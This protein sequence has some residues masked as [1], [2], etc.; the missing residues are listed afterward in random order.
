MKEAPTV[1]STNCGNT[2]LQRSTP[3]SGVTWYWQSSSSGTD[4]SNSSSTITVTTGS[5]Y[6]LRALD[7]SGTWSTNSSS[8][9]YSPSLSNEN[10]IY[11]V[12]PTEASTD[13]SSLSEDEIIDA[14]YFTAKEAHERK[15][16]F[17]AKQTAPI[18]ANVFQQE[19]NTY[20]NIVVPFT[21]GVKQSQV[22][23]NLETSFNEKGKNIIK[24]VC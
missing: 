18:I 5:I 7:S 2:V 8:V 16:D 21:D 6:Y 19:A 20:E 23:A 1:Q 4:T 24:T 15:A 17:I 22:L 9:V 10:Y 12:T 13:L 3:P 14:V 11:S